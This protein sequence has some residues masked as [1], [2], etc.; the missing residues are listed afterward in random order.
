MLYCVDLILDDDR[1]RTVLPQLAAD[2]RMR[3]LVV[4]STGGVAKRRVAQLAETRVSFFQPGIESVSPAAL[5]LMNKPTTAVKNLQTLKWCGE[6]GILCGWNYLSVIPGEDP[7]DVEAAANFIRGIHHLQPPVR[8]P[9]QIAIQR[10]SPYFQAPEKHGLGAF[11]V[12]RWMQDIFPLPHDSL[13]RLAYT[14]H[15]P[16]LDEQASHPAY[17]LL[18][19]AIKE[20]YRAWKT[21]FLVAVPSL[22]C[23]FVLDSRTNRRRI[24]HCLRGAE[25]EVFE[26]CDQ[27]QSI[28][29]VESF[30]AGTHL[31]GHA[32]AILNRLL[33]NRL[34]VQIDDCYL[35]LALWFRP[36]SKFLRTRVNEVLFCNKDLDSLGGLLNASPS[37]IGRWKA[38]LLRLK[39][40]EVGVPRLK[41]LAVVL[42]LR[43]AVHLAFM[44][45]PWSAKTTRRAARLKGR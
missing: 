19:W 2:K 11:N 18:E 42:L 20:W 10:F 3:A 35:S 41:S 12:A 44:L 37:E 32:G 26:F 4:E 27:G 45:A 7:G 29:R 8:G 28:A 43:A 33:A 14:F 38:R 24:W 1:Y 36:E 17:A 22:G 30:L 9:H 5:R 40:L 25:R 34:I 13:R 23:L 21:S 15:S 16:Q 39:L 31:A 6:M